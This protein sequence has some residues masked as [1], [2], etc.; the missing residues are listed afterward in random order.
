MYIMLN[1]MDIK[2]T[3]VTLFFVISYSISLWRFLMLHLGYLFFGYSLY[4]ISF[5]WIYDDEII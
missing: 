3:F 1:K 2:V 5:Q 4:E